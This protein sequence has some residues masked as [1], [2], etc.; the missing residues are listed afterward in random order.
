MA[1]EAI[2]TNRSEIKQLDGEVFRDHCPYPGQRKTT[3]IVT[4]RRVIC[5]KEIDFVGHFNKEWECLFENFY[6]P[7]AVT[8]SEL[9]IY[10]K[11]LQASIS[12]A[13]VAQQQHRMARQKSQRFLKLDNKH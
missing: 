7:P 10:C 4:N 13:Q 5:V 8:G 1:L 6:R 9:K 12:S 11:A 3:I 2:L